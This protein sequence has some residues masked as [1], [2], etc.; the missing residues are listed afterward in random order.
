MKTYSY[1]LILL[2]FS[3]VEND[4]R[5]TKINTK[6]STENHLEEDLQGKPVKILGENQFWKSQD[7]NSVTL[8]CYYPESN[9]DI[10]NEIIDKDNNVHPCVIDSLTTELSLESKEVIINA[11]INE[12]DFEEEWVA[13]CFEPHHGFVF[14]NKKNDIIGSMSFCFEC[15]QYRLKPEKV[16]YVPMKT[17]REICKK[18]NVPTNRVQIAKLY[19][20]SI[21]E[22]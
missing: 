8:Y 4:K 5:N 17:L 13:S 19:R 22:K 1:I 3:C 18:E 10:N 6:S 16:G 2:L 9:Y 14:K 20:I 7:I 12:T 15:N 21:K 11:L